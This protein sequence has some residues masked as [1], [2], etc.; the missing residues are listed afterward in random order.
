[1][2]KPHNCFLPNCHR[3]QH[4]HVSAWRCPAFWIVLMVVVPFDRAIPEKWTMITVHSLDSGKMIH[5]ILP[6]EGQS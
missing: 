4:L 3:V 6:T 1:M 2:G 5:T